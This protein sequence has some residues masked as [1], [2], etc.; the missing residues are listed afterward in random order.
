[1]KTTDH[2]FANK[3]KNRRKMLNKRW[4]LEKDPDPDKFFSPKYFDSL[5]ELAGYLSDFR[6]SRVLTYEKVGKNRA[7]FFVL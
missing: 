6:P 1:M 2:Y 7:V 3:V 5:D 4:V